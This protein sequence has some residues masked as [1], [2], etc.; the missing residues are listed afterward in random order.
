[1]N[2][3]NYIQNIVDAMRRRDELTRPDRS[4]VTHAKRAAWQAF[5]A[6]NGWRA[7]SHF[8]FG[9]IP[10]VGRRRA[11]R[12]FGKLMTRTGTINGRSRRLSIT[13]FVSA[14]AQAAR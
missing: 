3:N 4:N 12:G 9:D 5:V 13:N 11:P 10:L 14:S 8:L 7:S 6:L 1:M 2:S